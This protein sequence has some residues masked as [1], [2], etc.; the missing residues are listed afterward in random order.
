MQ[1]HARSPVELQEHYGI[2]SPQ[3]CRPLSVGEETDSEQ[4]CDLT[5]FDSYVQG[6]NKGAMACVWVV[7]QLILL[8]VIL[9]ERVKGNWKLTV[10]W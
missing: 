3:H 10:S 2:S 1:L 9:V 8:W 5:F 4:P 7:E 6:R